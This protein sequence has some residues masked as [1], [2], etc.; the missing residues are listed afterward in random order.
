V[1]HPEKGRN[2]HSPMRNVVLAL[3]CMMASRI[4][5]MPESPMTKHSMPGVGGSD[6]LFPQTTISNGIIHARIYLP[7]TARGY[8]RG[9]RFDWSGVVPEL[10]VHGHS[11][12]GQWFE[13]YAPTQHDAIMGPVESFDP[14]GYEEAGPGGS[15]LAI[16]IGILSR[17]D[18]AQYAPF[19]YYKLLN[20]GKWKVKKSAD[21]V[22]FEH[23][24][25]DTGYAYDYHKTLE[26][27]RGKPKLILRHVLINTGRRTIETN[28]YDHN[29]WL[30]DRQPVGPGLVIRLH[31]A[32][33]ATEAR[34]IASVNAGDGPPMGSLAMIKDSQ[35]IFLQKPDKR[36]DCYAVLKGYG[37]SAKD[38]SIHMENH[39]TGAGL[40]IE[41]DRPLTRLVFWSSSTIACPEP[42][43]RVKVR[44]GETFTWNI[45]YTFYESAVPVE[46]GAAGGGKAK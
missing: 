42:Y 28:V 27:V 35:I 9:A 19:R 2:N 44:P 1:D 23:I 29:L 14:L 6:S 12:A 17:P 7:D 3:C 46:S 38:Y 26:L 10:E 20:P 13:K 33:V 15:F 43:I 40:L 36:E 24:L 18:A 45:A 21:K 25:N 37:A 31:F 39:H 4:G 5:G 16:G 11:Y 8:Y 22:E 41:G 30:L 32:P 34:R